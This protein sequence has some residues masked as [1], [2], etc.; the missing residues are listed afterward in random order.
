MESP[1]DTHM[2]SNNTSGYKNKLVN[3]TKD[4]IN[5]SLLTTQS[6]EDQ[7]KSKEYMKTYSPSLWL[8]GC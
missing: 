3:D 7:S 4:L 5:D 1:T 6:K 2:D 8:T